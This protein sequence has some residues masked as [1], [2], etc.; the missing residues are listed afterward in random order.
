MWS[1]RKNSNRIVRQ[2]T[3]CQCPVNISQLPR[4]DQYSFA[5]DRTIALRHGHLPRTQRGELR[6]AGSAWATVWSRPGGHDCVRRALLSRLALIRCRLQGV[7]IGS[8]VTVVAPVR[9]LRTRCMPDRGGAPLINSTRGC[10]SE[11]TVFF[12]VVTL[13]GSSRT[14]VGPDQCRLS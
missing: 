2:G 12:G 1:G 6:V 3:Y 14:R 7:A 11:D 5:A 13:L 10:L 4:A 8:V 9:V